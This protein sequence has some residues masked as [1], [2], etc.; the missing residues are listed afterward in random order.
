M[1]I[2]EDFI[3]GYHRFSNQFDKITELANT[4]FT[5]VSQIAFL[6]IDDKGHISAAG[7]KPSFVEAYLDKD[8]YKEDPLWRDIGL[9][10]E[11]FNLMCSNDFQRMLLG[12]QE[13]VL[14]KSYEVH[15]GFCYTKRTGD[16]LRHYFFGSSKF[17]IYDD[18]VN[19]KEIILKLIQHI[20]NTNTDIMSFL[21]NTKS[22]SS[23]I[24]IKQGN[25]Y[26]IE[27]KKSHK[28]EKEYFLNCLKKLG[29]INDDT[30]FTN[31]EYEC[32]KLYCKGRS[33]KSIG[34]ILNISHRTVETHIVSVKNK[35]GCLSREE[36]TDKLFGP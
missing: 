30:N 7:N 6:E 14:G 16:I 25:F 32:L 29:L 12:S 13:Q 27:D 23:L 21:G 31:R 9:Q 24:D 19:N 4:V 34:K 2:T 36:M 10:K 8:L 33:S 28:T 5:E 1:S 15:H 18:L 20:V 3:R 35:I 11:G 22:S 26:S 17:G